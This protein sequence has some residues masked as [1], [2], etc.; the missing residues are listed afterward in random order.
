MTT[1]R[2]LILVNMFPRYAESPEV[3]K[4][5]RRTKKDDN[6]HE[7]KTKKKQ[8]KKCNEMRKLKKK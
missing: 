6:N 1:G 2:S 3:C 5:K 4:Q 8:K 7:K